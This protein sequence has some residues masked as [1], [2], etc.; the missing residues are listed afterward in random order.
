MKQKIYSSFLFSKLGVFL[1]FVLISLGSKAQDIHF[2]NFRMAPLSVN[3]ALTGSFKGSYRISS[4]YRDQWRSIDN[5]RPYATPFI[6]GEYNIAGGLLLD[7]DWISGGLSFQRDQSGSLNF[8]NQMTALNVGY[9]I[10]LDKNYLNVFSVGITYGNMTRGVNLQG[11]TGEILDN[12][13]PGTTPSP[14]MIFSGIGGAP[15]EEQ[16]TRSFSTLSIGVAYKA[17]LDNGSLIRFG[18]NAGHVNNP[19]ASIFS[20]GRD[21]ISVGGPR[22]GEQR[23]SF[24]PKI[25][26]HGEGSFLMTDKVRINPAILFQSQRGFREI[27]IQSTA[28]YMLNPEKQMTVIGGLGYRIGD[29]IEL[30][31]G[32]QI[33]DLKIQLS[34]DVTTS[35]LTQAGGGAFELALGYIGR[36]YKTPQVKPVIFCPRL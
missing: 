34:Y 22:P 9:H 23:D 7:Q 10:G 30:I 31:G 21:S 20:G 29:A 16:R 14:G 27:A 13:A 24:G 4:I 26:L 28:D 3:P 6:S 36:I 2:T 12:T 18:V 25:V 1:F 19:N 11:I 17:T 8:R 33:K 32:I 35:S 15:G 5:S